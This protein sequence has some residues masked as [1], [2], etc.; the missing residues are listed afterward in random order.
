MNK[1][2]M[3][4]DFKIEETIDLVQ[5]VKKMVKD[6]ATRKLVE[7]IVYVHVGTLKIEINL[8]SGDSEDE[9][10]RNYQIKM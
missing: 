9:V 10:R 6:E 4:H 5:G 1:L 7:D 8:Q 2:I 3:A